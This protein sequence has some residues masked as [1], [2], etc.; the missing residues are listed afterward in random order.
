MSPDPFRA[1]DRIDPPDQWDEIGRR[2]AAPGV[3]L[4]LG[5][6]PD[7]RPRRRAAVLVAA[8]AVAL[9]AGAVVATSGDGEPGGVTATST[10]GALRG[11]CPFTLDPDV[12][13]PPLVP[14]AGR[15][16]V[17][18]YTW[19]WRH[20]AGADLSV[21]GSWGTVDYGGIPVTVSVFASPASPQDEGATSAFPDDPDLI[22]VVHWRR[23][24]GA[25]TCRTAEVRVLLPLSE[26]DAAHRARG[27]DD[28]VRTGDYLTHPVAPRILGAVRLLPADEGTTTTSTLP[29]DQLAIDGDCPFRLEQAAGLGPLTP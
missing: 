24:E 3:D 19:S 20:P 25:E 8:A 26:E 14:A 1:L 28:L 11:P 12:V 2:A 17:P 5:A 6:V 21:P 10:P 27:D 18:A 13:V 9:V 23:V 4:D 15:P 7:I 16:P 22:E 29:A